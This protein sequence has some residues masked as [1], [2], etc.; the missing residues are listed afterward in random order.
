MSEEVKG[1]KLEEIR[2]FFVL[3]LLAV[4]ASIRTQSIAAPIGS[5][6]L[7]LN[8]I[9]DTMILLMSLYALLMV[10]VIQRT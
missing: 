6:T 3:G 2:A 4:L 1:S 10:F 5:T 7:P 9:I 8:P